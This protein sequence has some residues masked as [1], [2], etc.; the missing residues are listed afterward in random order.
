MFIVSRKFVVQKNSFSDPFQT[1]QPDRQPC[2][3][4]C[5]SVAGLQHKTK[6]EM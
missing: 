6:Q 5:Q 1:E 4:C 2:D 3:Q